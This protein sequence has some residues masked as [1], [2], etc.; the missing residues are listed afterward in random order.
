MIYHEL[1]EKFVNIPGV[2]FNVRLTSD[3]SFTVTIYQDKNRQECK[4][5]F[6]PTHGGRWIPT[7]EG[8]GRNK[9]QPLVA[10]ITEILMV[11]Y[12]AMFR[13]DKLS[14]KNRHSIDDLFDN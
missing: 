8:L 14:I 13:L 2:R 7:F 5:R 1:A 12:E 3:D 4:V 9:R 10:N 11:V 6:V